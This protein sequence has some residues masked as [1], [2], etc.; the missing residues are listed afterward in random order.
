MLVNL[1]NNLENARVNESKIIK[2]YGALQKICEQLDDNN[3]SDLTTV[4]GIE[5]ECGAVM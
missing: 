3:F 5:E 2:H 1:T 4:C